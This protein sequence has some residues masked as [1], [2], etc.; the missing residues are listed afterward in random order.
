MS[1]FLPLINLQ[2]KNGVRFVEGKSNAVACANFIDILADC[3]VS[4][5][6]SM[7]ATIPFFSVKFDGSQAIK[8]QIDRELVYIKIVVSSLYYVE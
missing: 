7:I 3:L 6:K 2:K 8:T 5:M 1:H 4:E